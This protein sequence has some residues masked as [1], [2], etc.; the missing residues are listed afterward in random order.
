VL[1][2]DARIELLGAQRKL[3]SSV[4][5]PPLDNEIDE[6]FATAVDE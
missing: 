1:V 2:Q 4:G 3:R 6:S 5:L